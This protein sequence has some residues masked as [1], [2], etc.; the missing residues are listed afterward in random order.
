MRL[1][2]RRTKL[3]GKA[4][5]QETPPSPSSFPSIA[6]GQLN[7]FRSLSF[8]F[9][10]IHPILPPLLS[11]KVSVSLPSRKRGRSPTCAFRFCRPAKAIAPPCSLLTV[12]KCLFPILLLCVPLCPPLFPRE[13]RMFIFPTGFL[14]FHPLPCGTGGSQARNSSHHL[15]LKREGSNG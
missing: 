8:S 7:P 6:W 14:L 2:L 5:P 13:G 12:G 11:F 4:P 10:F 1:C 15:S 9:P 3:L